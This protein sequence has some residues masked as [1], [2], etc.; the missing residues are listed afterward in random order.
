MEQGNTGNCPRN[1]FLF[2]VEKALIPRY[3]RQ[4]MGHVWSDANKFAKWLEVEIAAAETLAEAGQVPKEAAAGSRTRAKIDVARSQE[5]E[6]RGKH[7][8][9]ACTMAVSESIGDAS[10]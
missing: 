5:L 3:T 7:D 6:A 10:D 4:E 9:I 1:L 2:F 8:V